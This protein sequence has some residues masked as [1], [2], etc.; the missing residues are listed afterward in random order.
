M[1]PRD[2]SMSRR[3]AQ[4][5]LRRLPRSLAMGGMRRKTIETTALMNPVAIT[6]PPPS[7]PVKNRAGWGLPI[8]AA[9]RGQ[10]PLCATADTDHKHSDIWRR[11]QAVFVWL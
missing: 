6:S 10:N 5:R 8:H 4:R 2:G 1:A 9:R 7:D 3:V 11:R